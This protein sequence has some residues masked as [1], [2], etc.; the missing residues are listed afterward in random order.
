MPAAPR[1]PILLETRTSKI[2]ITDIQFPQG[3]VDL[4]GLPERR[5][6]F[7]AH[8]IEP[9]SQQST[10]SYLD[11]AFEAEYCCGGIVR[12]RQCLRFQAG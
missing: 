9:C 8:V 11:K 6:P 12:L 4:E 3:F 2:D 5:G 7:S 1:G 10:S